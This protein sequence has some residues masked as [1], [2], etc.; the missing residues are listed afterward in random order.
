[1]EKK[2]L[3][4]WKIVA[5]D[6]HTHRDTSRGLALFLTNEF[7]GVMLWRWTVAIVRELTI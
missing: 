2:L 1:M 5:E 3:G 4:N 6:L 7:I